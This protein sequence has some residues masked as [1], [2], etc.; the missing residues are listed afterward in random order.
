MTHPE[1]LIE[2]IL[3]TNEVHLLGGSSG[4]GKTTM[5]FQTLAAWQEGLP[6]FGHTSNP[7]PYCYISMDRSRSSVNRTFERL[8]LSGVITRVI[9][10]ED[11][12]S[13]ANNITAVI[14]ESLKIY[15]DAV[16]F[17]I[18]GYQTLVG[19][20]GNSYAPV[21]GLL[22]RSATLCAKRKIT[23]LGVAHSPKMKVDEKFQHPREMLLGSVAWAAYSD[24]IITMDLDETKGIITVRILPRNAASEEH[25]YTFG[26]NGVLEPADSAS[27][28]DRLRIKVAA[29]PVGCTL[30]TADI[31]KMGDSVGA[32]Q[33][34]AERVIKDCVTNKVLARV[35][36]GMYTRTHRS[37]LTI[38]GQEDFT[39]EV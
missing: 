3:P 27:P 16:F 25:E 5:V 11:L 22:K 10:Q 38:V 33:R 26:P 13:S 9:C 37:P 20:K 12:P 29:L 19:D 39:V 32:K 6:V 8:G 21:A 31:I 4:S 35:D 14:D 17:V 34:T 30:M 24:T 15:P 2:G 28:R 1:F 36:D 18:E 7:V 23:I